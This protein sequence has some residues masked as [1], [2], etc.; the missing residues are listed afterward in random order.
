MNSIEIEQITHIQI[1]Q[2]QELGRQTFA[3]TF[4]SGN[5]VDNLNQYLDTG[6]SID[7]LKTE[8][9]DKNSFFYFAIIDGEK[10]GY[11]KI[12]L[13]KSQTEI[14]EER[15]I[16]IERIYVLKEFYGKKVGQVLF[17][18][19]MEI[20]REKGVDYVWLGVWEENMRAI[21]FYK[22]NGFK[23][24]DKHI[25]KLGNEEQTD[26]MMKLELL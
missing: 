1:K 14:R 11:L 18:K 21:K 2:L 4:S 23:E 15:G 12:K 25:F 22:K 5:S 6:F 3:E 17:E 7:K 16:E 24:F 8:L 19:A 9:D 20:A 13:G 10:A 26:L